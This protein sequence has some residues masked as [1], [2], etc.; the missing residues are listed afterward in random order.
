MKHVFILLF[1]TLLTNLSAQD[2]ERH[3]YKVTKVVDGDTFYG[4]AKDSIEV[5]FRLIGIDCPESRH[6][7]K[8]K[9]PFS[10]EATQYLKTRIDNKDVYLE[11]DIESQDKYKRDLVYVFDSEGNNIN[12]ELVFNGFARVTTYVPNVR[13]E[14]LFYKNQKI[15]RE[16]GIG[17]W[18]I[19]YD[20]SA[21]KQD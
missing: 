2:Y 6:P 13:Y 1:T 7:K 16:L 15:A 18:S 8:P 4:M 20:F 19:E 9:Q 12:A 11:Y 21:I 17:M 5:K 14:S 3:Q 10:K